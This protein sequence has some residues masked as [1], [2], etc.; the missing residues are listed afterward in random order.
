MLSLCTSEDL[1]VV[2][3]H[4]AAGIGQGF[5]LIIA[6]NLLVYYEVF[7]QSLALSNIERMLRPVGLLL[8]NNALLELPNSEMR[9][10]GYQTVVYSDR[11]DDGDH[12]VWYQRARIR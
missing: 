10:V 2:L 7:E 6:N 5:N 4:L 11:P 3:E 12:I 1:N 9:S 8:S